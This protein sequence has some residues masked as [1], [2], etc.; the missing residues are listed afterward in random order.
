MPPEIQ[1]I[2]IADPPA[3]SEHPDTEQAVWNLPPSV[4]RALCGLVNNPEREE[5]I[6]AADVK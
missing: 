5:R 4:I 6:E 3:L 2:P 1:P